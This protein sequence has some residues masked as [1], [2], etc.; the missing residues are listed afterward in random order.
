M[1]KSDFICKSC[2][3][4]K[5]NGFSPMK[6]TCPTHKTLC[7][8]CVNAFLLG[9]GGFTCKKCGSSVLKYSWDYGKQKYKKV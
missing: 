4:I 1:A 6:F 3:Q 8:D 5:G 7:I 2:N 9:F